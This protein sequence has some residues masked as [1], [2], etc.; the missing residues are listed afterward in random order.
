MPLLAA[1]ATE[2]APISV[3][4]PQTRRTYPA[5]RA[6]AAFA[7]ELVPPRPM[8]DDTVLR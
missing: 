3:V 1:F 5:V 8:W 4:F 2:Q 6:V 7:A